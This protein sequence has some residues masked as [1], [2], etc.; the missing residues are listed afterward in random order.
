MAVDPADYPALSAERVF[1]VAAVAAA[2]CRDEA[3]LA[4]SAGV[5]GAA[6]AEQTA[7][8][9]VVRYGELATRAR[10]TRLRRSVPGVRVL[11]VAAIV[12]D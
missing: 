9:E 8:A 3:A 10:A 4:A 6:N 1:R 12:A 5:A 2:Q 11:G 7:Q